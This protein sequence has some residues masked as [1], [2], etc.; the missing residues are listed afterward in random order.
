MRTSVRVSFSREPEVLPLRRGQAGQRFR[1]APPAEASARL[2]L[3]ALSIRVRARALPR[4]QAALHRSGP[5]V[6]AAT[7]RSTDAISARVLQDE[8]LHGL[9]RDRSD[10]PRVSSPRQGDEVVRR[11][12]CSRQA[13]LAGGPGGDEEMRG[14]VRELPQTTPLP[15]TRDD[16]GGAGRSLSESGRRESNPPS[17]D[18][19]LMCNHNTSP[20][21]VSRF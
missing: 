4:E 7:P 2:V 18:G 21:V 11:R 16:S 19:N 17:E 20:A 14:G 10:D 8:P 1:L 9:W 3:S 6:Q 5:R 13:E 15:T 12:R